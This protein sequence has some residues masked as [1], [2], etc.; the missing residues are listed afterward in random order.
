MS[1]DGR[2]KLSMELDPTNLGNAE[3][4][5]SCVSKSQ[6]QNVTVISESSNR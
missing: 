5:G 2:W 1:A 3:V 4:M 6:C